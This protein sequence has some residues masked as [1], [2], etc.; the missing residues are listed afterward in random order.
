MNAPLEIVATRRSPPVIGVE[1]DRGAV[2]SGKDRSVPGE[3]A[4][5]RPGGVLH[6]EIDP[7]AVGADRE[8]VEQN[9]AFRDGALPRQLVGAGA[10]VPEVEVA[11]DGREAGDVRCGG[12]HEREAAVRRWVRR[13]RGTVPASRP[14]ENTASMPL[15][16]LVESTT[17]MREAASGEAASS[18]NLVGPS[19]AR[20]ET[21]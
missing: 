1:S 16:R 5:D 6:V 3:R 10:E 17:S 4:A 18:Q 12:G 20:N 2:G 13:R 7:L 19:G 14:V 21:V 15:K 8:R 9:V 11:V